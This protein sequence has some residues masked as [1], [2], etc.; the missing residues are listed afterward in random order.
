MLNTSL[1]SRQVIVNMEVTTVFDVKTLNIKKLKIVM[2]SI[3][4]PNIFNLVT[5]TYT[6]GIP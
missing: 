6:F 5:L 1:W 3:L 2:Y 4:Q